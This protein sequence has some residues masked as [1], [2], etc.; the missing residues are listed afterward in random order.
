MEER[1]LLPPQSF[2][3]PLSSS[4]KTSRSSSLLGYSLTHPLVRLSHPLVRIG[5]GMYFQDSPWGEGGGEGGVWGM[6][7][8]G[9]GGKRGGG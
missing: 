9:R 8:W 4:P 7:E 1:E 2:P 6:E 5:A 3:P